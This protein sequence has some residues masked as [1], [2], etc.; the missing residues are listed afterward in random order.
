MA[1][2]R[3]P[4]ERVPRVEHVQPVLMVR[5]LGHKLSETDGGAGIGTVPSGPVKSQPGP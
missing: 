3:R 4:S 2:G 1:D 5:Q